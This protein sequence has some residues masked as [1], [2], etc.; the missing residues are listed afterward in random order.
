[1]RFSK[2]S[3]LALVV[4][5]GIVAS[6][7]TVNVGQSECAATKFPDRSIEVIVGWGAGGG[8]DLFARA[9]C[10]PAKDILGVPLAVVNIPGANSAT[11]MGHVLNQKADG[12]TVFAITSDLLTVE[13]MGLLP[14][15]LETLE[16]LIRAHVDVAMIQVGKN[17]PFKTWEEFVKYAKENPDTITIGG[18]GAGSYDDIAVKVIMKSAGLNIRYVPFDSASEMH[19]ALMGGHIMAIHEETGPA[20]GYIEAK[21]VW[22]VLVAADQRLKAFNDVPCAGELKIEYVPMQWRGIAVKKGTPVEVV[23]I[24]EDA[25]AKA[26]ESDQYK[27]FEKDRYLDLYPG[28]LRGNDFREDM[29]KE[30]NQYKTYVKDLNL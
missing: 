12:Y 22:P 19:A 18:T 8:T 21:E 26:W 16:P 7:L 28:F 13:A 17:S 10:L 27:K 30:L 9:I 4:F 15:S 6:L 3:I 14:E 5:L 2:R 24:L 29:L 11:A 1:M 23:K 25:F 20:V